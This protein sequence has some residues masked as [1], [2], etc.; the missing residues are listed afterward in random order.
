MAAEAPLF[1][2]I[3]ATRNRAPLF[4]VALQS[5]LEQR[6]SEVEI[7]VVDDGSAE[8]QRPHYEALVAAVPR[9]R[10]FTLVR[11]ERGHGQSYALNHGAQHARGKY[12]CFLDDDDQWTDSGHLGRAAAVIA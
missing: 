9:A 2:V 8:E 6:F 11:R 5:V 3:L 7:I 10:M 1:S 12:L 4:T